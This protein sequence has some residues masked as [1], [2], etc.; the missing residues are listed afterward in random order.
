MISDGTLQRHTKSTQCLGNLL[1]DSKNITPS[2]VGKLSLDEIIA[3]LFVTTH[4][5]QAL[6]YFSLL[7]FSPLC[8]GDGKKRESSYSGLQNCERLHEGRGRS[9]LLNLQ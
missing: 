6:L 8:R 7:H 5:Q 3:G 4:D 1:S 9:T 2:L